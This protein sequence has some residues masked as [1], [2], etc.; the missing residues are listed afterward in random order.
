M[1]ATPETHQ[2]L[3]PKIARIHEFVAEVLI[4]AKH[5]DQLQEEEDALA[6]AAALKGQLSDQEVLFSNGSSGNWTYPQSS[7]SE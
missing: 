4:E 3:L 5:L 6:V 2:K 1:T 7:A